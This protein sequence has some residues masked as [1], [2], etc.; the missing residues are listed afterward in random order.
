M[1][2]D[3]RNIELRLKEKGL[4]VTSK[5]VAII[6]TVL[7]LNNH[8]TA[9]EIINELKRESPRIAVATVYKALNILVEKKVLNKVVTDSNVTRYDAIQDRHFHLV[10]LQADT[11]EDYRDDALFVLLD[12]YFEKKKIPGFDIEN[13]EI[14]IVGKRRKASS[15]KIK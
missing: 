13:I 9:D 1:Q 12:K 11:I 15:K 3:K 14:Q 6:E 2:G 5:R 4:K 10:N 8:P 7:K